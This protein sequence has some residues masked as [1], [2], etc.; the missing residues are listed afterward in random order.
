MI[1]PVLDHLCHIPSSGP[2]IP[3]Q[4]NDHPPRR[5]SEAGQEGS[6][7]AHKV[8]GDDRDLAPSSS[9]SALK[10]GKVPVDPV[11][12][13]KKTKSEKNAD[14]E[15]IETIG[16]MVLLY[17]VT[18]TINIPPLCWHIYQHHGSVMGCRML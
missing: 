14:E 7:W 15:T 3:Y 10:V 1:H 9:D 8:P 2:N 5:N 11:E 17:M 18:F 4:Q 16:S 13:W 6:T 12:S